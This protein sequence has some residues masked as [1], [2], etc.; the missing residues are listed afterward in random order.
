MLDDVGPCDSGKEEL[1]VE[2]QEETSKSRCSRGP[3]ERRLISRE[4]ETQ[5]L[6]QTMKWNCKSECDQRENRQDAHAVDRGENNDQQSAKEEKPD[7]PGF[8]GS[9]DEE[10]NGRDQCGHESAARTNPCSILE[11]EGGD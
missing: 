6:C 8:H 4:R 9:E 7:V 3:S 2:E 11:E 10:E 1:N 5:P